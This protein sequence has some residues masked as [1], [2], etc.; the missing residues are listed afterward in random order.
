MNDL[1]KMNHMVKNNMKIKASTTLVEMKMVKAGGHVT[2]GVDS[3]T[4]HELS[5]SFGLGKNDTYVIMYVIDKE[6]FDKL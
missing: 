5:K 2:M 1:E 3:N 4:Y 6:Q